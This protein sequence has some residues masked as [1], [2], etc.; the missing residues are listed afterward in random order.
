MELAVLADA[1]ILAH[2]A[3]TTVPE[4]LRMIRGVPFVQAR[5]RGEI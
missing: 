3:W 4:L 1:D 2:C 5:A